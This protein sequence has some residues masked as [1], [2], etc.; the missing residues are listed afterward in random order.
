MDD[1]VD[2]SDG[3]TDVSDTWI[4]SNLWAKSPFRAMD[5]IRIRFLLAF[6]DKMLESLRIFSYG[7]V[8]IS[9]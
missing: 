5:Q 9:S 3:V 1:D 7:S 6:H 8:L 2:V 4:Q